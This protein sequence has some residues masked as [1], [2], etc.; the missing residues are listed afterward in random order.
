MSKWKNVPRLWSRISHLPP[1]TQLKR[2]ASISLRQRDT[3]VLGKRSLNQYQAS[4]STSP[5]EPI[6]FAP[7]LE[8]EQQSLYQR[9]LKETWPD[10]NQ[11]EFWIDQFVTFVKANLYRWLPERKLKSDSIEAYLKGSNAAP[12]VKRQVREAFDRL[13]FDGEG[14]HTAFSKNRQYQITRRKAFV[15]VENLAYKSFEGMK[16]K[17]PRLI[18]GATPEFISIVGPFFSRFQRH[19]KQHW[20]KD[21]F[22]YFTSGA[23]AKEAADYIAESEGWNIFENDVSAYDA[24]ITAKLCELECWIAKQYG[25][26]LAVVDLMR[27]NIATHGFTANGWKYKVPGTRKSGDP[28]T[29]VF[30]S[31]LNALMHVFVFC[32]RTN[33]P[34]DQV[35]EHM[36]MLVQG[37]DNLL[38]H[39][40]PRIEWKRMFVNLGFTTVSIYRQFLH[41][42]EFCSSLL[43]SCSEGHVF[44]PKPGKLLAKFGYFV[45]PPLHEHPHAL[46]RGVILGFSHLRVLDV[47]DSYFQNV[48]ASLIKIAPAYMRGFEEH[49]LRQVP[50]EPGEATAYELMERYLFDHHIWK[51]LTES[52]KEGK[53]HHPYVQA[54]FD[55]DTDGPKFIYTKC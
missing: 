40:G 50:F 54:L 10:P 17:A 12:S 39:T 5:Y 15:K 37:D 41:E 33:T 44:I 19:V 21:F 24:S 23:S 20:N 32:V 51:H 6:Y 42:A 52:M 9:V 55:R 46:L 38:R 36:R 3:A 48:E 7:G 27:A 30:N 25:A 49:K 1:P 16:H 45:N 47:F 2:G 22:L 29:S 8:N 13:A 31:M 18:Q 43:V 35:H 4:H 34:V 11:D 14:K 26:P 53:P 28:Y